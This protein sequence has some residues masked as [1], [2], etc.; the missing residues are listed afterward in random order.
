MM[1]LLLFLLLLSGCVVTDYE[2]NTCREG[3]G[4][5]GV[6]KSTWLDC[7]CH[8]PQTPCR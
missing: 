3:C 4:I 5:R 1:K 7:K 2:M 8:P 6:L